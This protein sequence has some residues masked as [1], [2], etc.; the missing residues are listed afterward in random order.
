[1]ASEAEAKPPC[2]N[3]RC[4]EIFYKDVE[5]P[6]TEHDLR[7]EQLYGK[8]DTRSYWC[9]GTQTGRG[10]DGQPVDRPGCSLRTRPCYKGI[11]NLG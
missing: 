3:L 4:K 2:L 5:A 6:P 9:Q 8:F 7:V 11:E 1:M 10:P